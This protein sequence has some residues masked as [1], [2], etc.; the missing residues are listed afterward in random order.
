MGLAT[1]DQE[2][3]LEFR[4]RIMTTEEGRGGK[5]DTYETIHIRQ[6]VSGTLGECKLPVPSSFRTRARDSS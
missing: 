4:A 2:T 3:E 5:N 6:R 1:Q